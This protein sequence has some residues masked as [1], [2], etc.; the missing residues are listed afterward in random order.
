MSVVLLSCSSK[1]KSFKETILDL[2]QTPEKLERARMEGSRLMELQKEI[3]TILDRRVPERKAQMDRLEEEQA[4][5]K[6]ARD[7]FR[8]AQKRREETEEL[9]EDSRAGIL[10]QKLRDGEK[11][12]VCGSIHHPDPARIPEKAADEAELKACREEESRLDRIKNKA[13]AS[14]EGCKSALLQMNKQLSSD[15]RTCLEKSDPGKDLPGKDIPDE[16]L[17][18]KEMDALVEM[19]KEAGHRM[20]EE[21]GANKNVQNDLSQKNQRLQ[22]AEA[23]LE[24][25]QWERMTS[26]TEKKRGFEERKQK[27]E[28]EKVKTTAELQMLSGLSYEHWAAAEADKKRMENAAKTILDAIQTALKAK[29]KAVKEDAG[30]KASI[31]T[32]NE[33]LKTQ[34]AEEQQLHSDFQ[35]TL[36]AQKFRTEEEMLGYVVKEAEIE[37][38]ERH[39]REYEQNVK[40]NAVQ[41]EGAAAEAKGKTLIDI[42][43]LQEL[44]ETQNAAFLTA[45]KCVSSI[46]YRIR[47]NQEKTEGMRGRKAGLEK[48][49]KEYGI[50]ERLYNLVRGQTRNGKIT[51]EQYVQATGFDG[52]IKAANRRLLPMSDKQYELYRQEDSVGKKTNTFLDLEVLDNY[53]G[54]RRPVGNLSGGESFKA[55]LSLA[56]GLSDTVSSN[57]G[58]IQMDALFVDEGFG[59]LDRKSIENAMDIL[60]HLSGT[61]KLV[62]VISHREELIENIPQQIRVSKT[63]EGSKIIIENG[64]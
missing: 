18:E 57:L 14:A 42:D 7:N 25:A 44:K 9:L 20:R 33:T 40:T 27:N 24:K 46:E 50:C 3:R 58:G 28:K 8:A 62:G 16:E 10:A 47:G 48:A 37:S 2:K 61:S 60:L 23:D 13:L 21:I 59:T 56:L 53:T 15:I 52:I 54:H 22:K 43:E 26:L 31:R 5:Y 51:L 55:S 32:L 12:P 41:L 17:P 39:I 64:L 6:T 1:V 29:E 34:K 4:A 36:E 63:K 19:L 35:N 38:T 11:C 49:R 30:V 45:G